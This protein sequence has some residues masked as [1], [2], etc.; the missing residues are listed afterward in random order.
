MNLRIKVLFSVVGILS[1][2]FFVV[3][4]VLSRVLRSDYRDLERQ[5][6]EEN[7]TRVSDAL[8]NEI[9]SLSVKISD[10]GQWDDTYIFAQD[11]NQSYI[12]V[13]LQD[14]SLEL[15]HIQFIVIID[16]NGDILFKKQID[17]SGKEVVFSESFENYI[18]THP[19][20]TVHDEG[21]DAHS[22]IIAL[23]DGVIINVT[24]SITSSDGLSPSAG[25]IMF[26][27][28]VD[29]EMASKIA[30]LTHFAVTMRPFREIAQYPSFAAAR[31]I[32][33]DQTVFIA[34]R[35]E[36]DTTVSGY[37]IKDDMDGGKTLVMRVEFDRAIYQR[38]QDS[39]AFFTKILLGV[40]ILIV[41][42]ILGLFEVLVLRRLFSLGESV[43][44]V[45]KETGH[46][47]RITLPGKDE[48]SRLANRI[49]AMLI[50]LRDMEAKKRESEKLFYAIADSAPVMIWVMDEEK[51]CIYFNKVWLDF[52]GQ[53][54]ENQLSMGWMESIHP[55]DAK[56]Q[57]RAFEE[58]FNKHESY[59]SEYRLRR[60]DGVYVWVFSQNVPHYSPEGTFLG[61]LCSCLDITE[62]KLVEE[63][64]QKYI[65]QIEKI[66]KIMIDR[67]L[68]MIELKK[69]NLKLQERLSEH[70]VPMEAK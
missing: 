11:H 29:D 64:K 5:V 27:T 28:F 6:A 39:I 12:D 35:S 38:G 4:G 17:G 32:G 49:D 10:W 26:A 2:L 61:Y 22:G 68:R 63:K 8:Q 1:I 55:D 47:S 3:Y 52:T 51:K 23:S 37:T 58:A 67:E 56:G 69:Q 70:N 60:V 7:V 13:N 62:I 36:S 25:T 18:Q 16:L 54:L 31:Y 59:K 34:E 57:R 42:V 30:N 40:G 65:D 14:I 21:E 19:A 20:L 9:D 24:H 44:R 48:F 50:S 45:S 46:Q 33:E 43:E 66:N 53:T 15:L 41:I